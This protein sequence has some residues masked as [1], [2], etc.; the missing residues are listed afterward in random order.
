ME[1]ERV[2]Y[3][4]EDG[5][6]IITIN[7]PEKMNSITDDMLPILHNI[8]ADTILDDEVRAVI[9]TGTG[10]AFCA[11]ADVKA[12]A[13]GQLPAK[14][15]RSYVEAAQR[16]N[17]L[18]QTV[19][20]PVVAAVN[21]HAIG[22]GLELA[23]SC[24]FVVVASEAKLRLPEVS[25]GTFVGGG[26]LYTLPQRIGLAKAKE[27]ILLG[28][29]L[30]GAQAAEI[31]LANRVVPADEVFEEA[32]ALAQELASKAPIPMALAKELF[33]KA[34]YLPA[35]DLLELEA[36]ALLRCMESSD[37]REGLK[38]FKEKRE[39]RYTGE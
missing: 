12:H 33:Y 6:G 19:P 1:D 31:G 14:D 26:L 8:V 34:R 32:T 21:G 17:R 30:T 13:G 15:R 38:A 5:I 3:T 18:L 20:K 23:L 4:K 28:D 27:M 29:F 16:V 35:D 9:V 22:A 25:L 39:P 10:R 7:R 36:Q 37:W 11:G 2:L 24:D